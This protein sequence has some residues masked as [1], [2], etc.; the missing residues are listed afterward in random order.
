[1][2]ASR[3]TTRYNEGMITGFI[4]IAG[5]LVG[6]F[7]NVVVIRLETGQQFFFGR[8]ACQNCKKQI[9]WYDNIPLISFFILGGR[10]RNCR[11]GIS[12]Q[13]PIVELGTAILFAW[14][15]LLFGLS[16]LMLV[17]IL[18]ISF[19]VVIFVYDFQHQ[20]I[21]DSVTIPAMILALVLNLV[22]GKPIISLLVGAIIGS[23]FF[24]LQYFISKGQ[25]I[26]D[27]DIRL[28]AVMGL[29]LGWPGVL[30]A[31]FIAYLVGAVIGVC[32]LASR[33]AAMNQAVP[34][35]PFLAGAT[36]ISLW[37]GSDIISWY[38]NMLY[39]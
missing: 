39:F 22:L 5:L 9:A 16:F 15:Y 23:G 34:F 19:L 27:G 18:F 25:W 3:D 28:G 13:Y 12:W 7:L 33:R 17:Q 21:P 35:G 38:L 32:L 36:V 4:F 31:L 14:S 37:Y 26:G 6:S 24:A 30:V 11:A 1:M 20:L 8:S 2:V 29:M 10:C